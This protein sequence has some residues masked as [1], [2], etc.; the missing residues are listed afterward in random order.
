M[1]NQKEN[2]GDNTRGNAKKKLQAQEN[3]DIIDFVNVKK[4]VFGK[5]T[6]QA[7]V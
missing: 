1:A 6:F 4:R 5:E 2:T 3:T 7:I